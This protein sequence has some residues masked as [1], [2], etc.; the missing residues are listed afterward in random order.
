MSGLERVRWR[1]LTRESAVD[2]TH[3]LV[4]SGS[5]EEVKDLLQEEVS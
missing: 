2:E 5:I 4:K 3:V 1:R